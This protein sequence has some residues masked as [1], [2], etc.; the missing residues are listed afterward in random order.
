MNLC[1]RVKITY[2]AMK[3]VWRESKKY[4][5]YP[6]DTITFKLRYDILGKK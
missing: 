1:L 4:N 2:K 6:G 3:N 5:V